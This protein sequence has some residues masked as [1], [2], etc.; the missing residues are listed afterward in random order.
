MHALRTFLVHFCWWLTR[1]SESAAAL[2]LA[3]IVVANALG[4][5]YRY[6]LVDPI[7]WTEEGMR[8]AVI[9]ATFLAGAAALYRGEHMVLNLFDNV[10]VL[11]LRWAAHILV[12]LC[13]AAFC[14]VVAWQGWPL[15]VRNWRQV[16]PT[17]NIPM[18][19]PYVAV[20]VGAVL[21]LLKTIALVLMPPGFS[22]RELEERQAT[23]RADLDARDL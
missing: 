11:W 8:Y 2:L 4:V 23:L 10:A 12:L 5:F 1:I 20:T 9:W 14:I 16:S 22:A 6:V 17:M 13:I 3:F 21:M 19:F 18:F 15:A 7:G